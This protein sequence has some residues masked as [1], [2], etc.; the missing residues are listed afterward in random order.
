MPL[1]PHDLDIQSILKSCCVYLLNISSI[2]PIL[3]TSSTTAPIKPLITS[4]PHHYHNL[5]ISLTFHS[6]IHLSSCHQRD[7]SKLLTDHVSPLLKTPND[8]KEE[9]MKTKHK[10]FFV[11]WSLSTS[12]RHYCNTISQTWPNS[13]I[14][15]H[16]TCWF[17]TL[18]LCSCCPLCLAWL[19]PFFAW[20]ILG[21][22]LEWLG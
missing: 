8:P 16:T 7:L 5:L 13:K 1:F 19:C 20:L 3:A 6:L 22:Q 17:V 4:C 21:P 15:L 18:C 14:E 2:F 10:T 9:R 12:P 11:T